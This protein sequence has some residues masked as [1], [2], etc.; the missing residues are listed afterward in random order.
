MR[1]YLLI[2][3]D[4]AIQ[5]TFVLSDCQNI[6][7]KKNRALNGAVNTK[8]RLTYFFCA[9]SFFLSR[10]LREAPCQF[11][12]L[13]ITILSFNLL[14]THT[15]LTHT[16]QHLAYR[17]SCTPPTCVDVVACFARW[18]A[19]IIDSNRVAIVRNRSAHVIVRTRRSL[20]ILWDTRNVLRH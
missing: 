5:F 18:Y 6:N 16:K 7:Y 20:W 15:I 9:L 8:L 3:S 14:I 13:A 12:C 1:S 4:P 2:I 17:N 11:L 10:R 19:F